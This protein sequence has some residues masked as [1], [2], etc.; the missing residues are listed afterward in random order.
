MCFSPLPKRAA[1]PSVNTNCETRY[2]AFM[3]SLA[4]SSLRDEVPCPL[5]QKQLQ[6]CYILMHVFLQVRLKENK[7][8]RTVP[9]I[10]RI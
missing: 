7:L 4:V 10:L 9:S 1:C 8:D 2:A 5:K 3:H 6:L